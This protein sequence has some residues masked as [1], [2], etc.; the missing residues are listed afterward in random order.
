MLIEQVQSDLL[1][2]GKKPATA[3]RLIATLKHC[4]HKGQ[5]WEK[6]PEET[7]KRVRQ[8]KFLQ[9]NNRRLR[10]LSKDECRTLLNNSNKYIKAIVTFALNTGCRRGEILSLKWDNVD[11]K[12]GFIRLDMTKNGER[13]DI[14]VSDDLKAVLQGITRRL[15]FPMSSL[16]R[17]EES[18]SRTLS[19]AFTRL[20]ER[21][22]LQ[23]STF[24][25][26]DIP[27]HLTWLWQ[28]LILRLY[29]NY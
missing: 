9:E 20:A 28:E 1:N 15:V 4:I 16:M 7:L 25:T 29:R 6:V 13:R 21:P 11:M 22:G 27:L 5:Q 24:T 18:L 14:P 10:Y 2:K 26:S 17:P 12:H 19:G 23:T 8:V 3:N